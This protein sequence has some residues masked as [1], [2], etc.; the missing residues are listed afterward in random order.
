M[1]SRRHVGM[2]LFVADPISPEIRDYDV[3]YSQA[4]IAM[5]PLG[6]NYDHLGKVESVYAMET[7]PIASEATIAMM[8]QEVAIDARIVGIRQLC[9][10]WSP[11][12]TIRAVAVPDGCHLYVQTIGQAPPDMYSVYAVEITNPHDWWQAWEYTYVDTVQVPAWRSA[13]P[14]LRAAL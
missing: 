12:F 6:Q 14:M 1:E 13:V 4:S 9:G 2:L 7:M 5:G 3:Y 11:I 10:Y 8:R